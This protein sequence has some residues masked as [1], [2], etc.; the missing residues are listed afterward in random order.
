MEAGHHLQ[1]LSGASGYRCL[2]SG[3]PAFHRLQVGPLV[4]SPTQFFSM[5]SCVL[6]A[7]Q[8]HLVPS[9]FTFFHL[10]VL[11]MWFM[12]FRFG[13]TRLNHVKRE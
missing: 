8:F 4:V 11:L 12:W 10:R 1:S 6:H 9:C 13:M 2:S 3:I 7:F 5:F